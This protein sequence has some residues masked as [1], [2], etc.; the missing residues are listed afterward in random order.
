MLK[1]VP[2]T[3]PGP[4][5][6]GPIDHV[7]TNGDVDAASATMQGLANWSNSHPCRI[8]IVLDEFGVWLHMP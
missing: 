8:P 5:D 7:Y 4:G 2:K 6:D 3:M 1:M